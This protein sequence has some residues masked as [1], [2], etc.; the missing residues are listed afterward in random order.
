ML[1]HYKMQM[2][3]HSLVLFIVHILFIMKFYYPAFEYL[4]SSL[5]L[6]IFTATALTE[7]VVLICISSVFQALYKALEIKNKMVKAVVPALKKI[8]IEFIF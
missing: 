7:T 1:L 8:T 5:L 6:A 2:L 3:S 4:L